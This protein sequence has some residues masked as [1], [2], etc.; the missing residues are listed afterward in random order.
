[1][2]RYTRIFTVALL[3]FKM[4]TEISKLYLDFYPEKLKLIKIYFIFTLIDFGHQNPVVIFRPN[5]EKTYFSSVI[6]SYTILP[7]AIKLHYIGIEL[8]QV[9]KEETKKSGRSFIA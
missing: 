5:K 9:Y 8:K 6:L 4:G 2:H 7:L 3:L 1:M